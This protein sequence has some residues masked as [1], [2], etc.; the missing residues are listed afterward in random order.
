MGIRAQAALDARAIV[1][2]ATDGF[3]WAVT[4]ISPA[5]VSRELTGLTTDIGRAIDPE[6][7]QAVSGRHASVVLSIAALEEAGLEI[8]KGIADGSS[9]P[10]IVEFADTDGNAQSFKV[11]ASRP[12][13]AIGL[14]TLHLEAIRRL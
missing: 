6:T 2:D 12:D 4:V 9:K 3:G 10:W 14:V 13:R 8:P 1:E 5:G 7:G 11:S